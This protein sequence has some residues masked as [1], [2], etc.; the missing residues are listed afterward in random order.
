M[1]ADLF[2]AGA[3]VPGRDESWK[4]FA[5]CRGLDVQMF[6]PDP[7]QVFPV[8]LRRLCE[9]CPVRPDCLEYALTGREQ[10]C[11]AGTSEKERRRMTRRRLCLRC[12][13]TQVTGRAFYCEPCATESR[14]A[15]Q[16][17]YARA[18]A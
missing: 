3:G 6:Y 9:A 18:H 13:H 14:K 10:G 4:D 16:Q 5:S 2:I 7:G 8:K 15:S 17:A 11:W 1:V 12:G